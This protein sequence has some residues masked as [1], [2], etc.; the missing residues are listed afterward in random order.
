MEFTAQ[1]IAE[2]L[3][4]KVE[5]DKNAIVNTFSKI[6][7]G[8]AGSLCFLANPKYTNYIYETEAS[9]V[10]VNN[11]FEALK[12]IK[13]SLIRVEDAYKSIAILLDIYNQM[14]DKPKGIE[15]QSFIHKSA[16]I[17][18]N[19]YVGAF[20]YIAKDVKIGNNVL[21]YPGVYIGNNV[22]IGDIC[23]FLLGV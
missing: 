18:K 15:K 19:I 2:L 10:L 21:I 7:E 8:K 17:G 16:V 4:G 9:V 3:N 14:T 20:A 1:Q 13:A 5:G 11:D 22:T 6:E 23:V 12:P